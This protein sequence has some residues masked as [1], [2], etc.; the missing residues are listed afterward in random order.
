MSV[1]KRKGKDTYSYDFVIRGQ[2]F[3]GDTGETTKRAAERFETA[4]REAAKLEVADQA[5]LYGPTLTFDL[6]AHRWWEE[7]G[8]HHKNFETTLGVLDWLK[9]H[10][11][12]KTP[13]EKVTDSVVARLVAKRRGDY[14]K[15]DPKRG[16]VSPATVNRTCTQPL[17]EIIT[18]AKRVWRVAVA[19][20]DFGKHM[21]KEPQERVREASVAEEQ[22]I[23]AQL[24]RGYDVAV[25][26]AFL[27]GCRR[28]EIIGLEWSH[29]DFFTRNFTVTGKGG[30]SRT[31]PMSKAIYDLLW[32]EKDHHRE[33]VFTY[34]AKRT[35]KEL[36][37]IKGK[38][39]PLTEAGLK[40]AMRRAVP[41]AGVVNFRFHD[42]RHTAATRV[43]RKSNLRVAQNLLGH[44]D[45][46]TTTKYAH[47]VADDIRNALDAIAT[48]SPTANP[49]EHDLREGKSLTKGEKSE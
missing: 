16:F 41:G 15:G 37:I 30:K 19:D 3:S 34:V 48:D 40:T 23:M 5:A 27:S 29:I 13:L 35:R 46:K 36:G 4:K 9:R 7:V 45:I 28:M 8:Q 2:R 26:F 17:R 47:A 6:A 22:A 43:L 31:L 32:G 20:V 42:T 39:Y 18:R 38:R 14:V 44:S 11:G 24:E 33:K 49:T 12:A 1:Y 21:L 10:I 25:R